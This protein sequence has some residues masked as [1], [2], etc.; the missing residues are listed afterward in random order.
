MSNMIKLENVY[1]HFYTKKL[2]TTALN[3][4]SLQVE[5]GE[6]LAITGTSGSGKSTL[7]NAIGLFSNIDEGLIELNG[8]SVAGISQKK[9][10]KYRREHL[11]Y[12]FQSFNLIPDLSVIENVMLPLKFRGIGLKERMALAEQELE[13]LSLSSRC[14]HYPS[15]LSGGQQQRVA[16]ARTM[17]CQPSIILADEPTGNLDEKTGQTVLDILHHANTACDATIVMVTHSDKAA[18]MANRQVKMVQGELVS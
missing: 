14:D 18:S 1:K 9:K 8:T 2:K 5:K 3:N 10:L 16:I 15:Q 13:K 4:V 17:A 7:L 11:G 12:V 6:F